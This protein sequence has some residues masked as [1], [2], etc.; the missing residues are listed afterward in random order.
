[1]QPVIGVVVTR[2]LALPPLSR[3]DFPDATSLGTKSPSALRCRHETKNSHSY[4]PLR[5]LLKMYALALLLAM[6]ISTL[7]AGI[8]FSLG[9]FLEWLRALGKAYPRGETDGYSRRPCSHF[10]S[11]RGAHRG[12]LNVGSLFLEVGSPGLV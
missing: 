6:F 2:G 9:D 5:V 7:H 8:L 11:F 1:M 10:W 4:R 3:G 12:G